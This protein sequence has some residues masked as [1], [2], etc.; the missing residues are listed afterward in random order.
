MDNGSLKPSMVRDKGKTARRG[1]LQRRLEIGVYSSKQPRREAERKPRRLGSDTYEPR[2]NLSSSESRTGMG[3]RCRKAMP[4]PLETG[5]RVAA[6][7]AST[8]PST[9]SQSGKASDEPQA[10]HG[11]SSPQKAR[12]RFDEEEKMHEI[13]DVFDQGRL[14]AIIAERLPEIVHRVL[15]ARM[16]PGVAASVCLHWNWWFCDSAYMSHSPCP[17]ILLR[18]TSLCT[19]RP[20]SEVITA[21]IRRMKGR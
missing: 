18:Y 4:H 14:E 16:V 12:T 19:M 2:M 7:T 17:V 13:R 9:D 21:R 1:E 8:I 20:S 5:R 3:F 10:K 15:Q 11:L 6:T